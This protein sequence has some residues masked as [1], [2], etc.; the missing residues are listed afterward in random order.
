MLKKI[1]NMPK[2]ARERVRLK[3]RARAIE[4]AKATII[5]AGR[6]IN[7][8]S[9]EELEIIVAEEERKLLDRLK[10]MSIVGILAF[11]GISIF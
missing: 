9:E 8:L 7:E 3:L 2:Q 11:F 5:L 4:A 10:G 6:D 1:T